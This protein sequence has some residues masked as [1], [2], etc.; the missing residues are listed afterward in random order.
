MSY[1]TPPPAPVAVFPA[2][3][4]PELSPPP[5]SPPLDPLDGFGFEFVFVF[6]SGFGFWFRFAP[7]I[8]KGL[9]RKL[10]RGTVFVASITTL[11]PPGAK[12]HVWPEIVM[13]GESGERVWPWTMNADGAGGF[14]GFG[15]GSGDK[16]G[17]FGPGFEGFEGVDGLGSGFE[18]LEGLWGGEGLPV[19]LAGGVGNGV[20]AL[21]VFPGAGQGPSVQVPPVLLLLSFAGPIP[22]LRS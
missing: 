20:P 12:E 3:P 6:G 2:P 15:A 10:A 4:P 14:G 9:A 16:G 7:T 21:A 19:G 18:G 5:L 17:A 8:A 22:S 13:G 11:L 1:S